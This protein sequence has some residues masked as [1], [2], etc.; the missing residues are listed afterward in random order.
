[1][2]I[3]I[4]FQ[5]GNHIDI[6][7]MFRLFFNLLFDGEKPYHFVSFPL[8]ILNIEWAKRSYKTHLSTIVTVYQLSNELERYST[9]AKCQCTMCKGD[10]EV[11]ECEKWCTG[12]SLT[13]VLCLCVLCI[14][15]HG[16]MNVKWSVLQKSII[17]F[18]TFSDKTRRKSQD[19]FLRN[20]LGT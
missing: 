5:N 7:I 2:Q 1:M 3:K 13:S 19:A 17:T 9:W 11:W 18:V 10:R 15:I 8:Q 16:H 20:T 4:Y 12:V 6:L 14:S